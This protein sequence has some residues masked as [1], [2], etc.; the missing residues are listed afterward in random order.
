MN[1]ATFRVARAVKQALSDDAPVRDLHT[2]L[3]VVTDGDRLLR[4]WERIAKEIRA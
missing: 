1:S 2:R 4:R 3:Q